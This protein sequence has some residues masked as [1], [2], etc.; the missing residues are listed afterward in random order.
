MARRDEQAA[1]QSDA[2][3]D[4][5]SVAELLHH[6]SAEARLAGGRHRHEEEEERHRK[7]VVQSGFD[8]QGLPDLHGNARAADDDL[9]E[10]GVGGGEDGREDSRLEQ[11]D[12][13]EDGP[14]GD[15]AEDERQQH[16]DAQQ[17]RRERPRVPQDADVGPAGVGEQEQH[18]AE[19]GHGQQRAD[20]VLV[21]VE[22]GPDG[23]RRGCPRS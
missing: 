4:E 13:G 23:V 19:L 14:G 22:L 21:H 2:D 6:E 7:A 5:D 20:P 17:A 1:G 10:P 12:P 16:A 11:R 3:A 15:G 9:A 8:V 18:E